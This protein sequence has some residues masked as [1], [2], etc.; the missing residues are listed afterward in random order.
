MKRK[1]INVSFK[2]KIKKYIFVPFSYFYYELAFIFFIF[3]NENKTDFRFFFYYWF[4]L[5]Q[6]LSWMNLISSH[7]LNLCF[8][9]LNYLWIVVSF[10][11]FHWG[12]LICAGGFLLFLFNVFFMESN[13]VVSCAIEVFAFFQTFWKTVCSLRRGWPSRTKSPSNKYNSF[14][15]NK[16][17]SRLDSKISKL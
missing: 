8:I 13:R 1:C 11:D 4:S 9:F 14:W 10:M 17:V 5:I 7:I 2:K 3:M 6:N 16:F 12:G 15:A